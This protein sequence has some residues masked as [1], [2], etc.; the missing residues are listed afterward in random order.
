MPRLIIHHDDTFIAEVELD[1]PLFSIGRRANND[2]VLS[3]DGAVSGTHAQITVDGDTVIVEDQQSTNGTSVNDTPIRQKTLTEGDV[4]QI[5]RHRLRVAASLGSEA[6]LILGPDD[7]LA[8]LGWPEE[9][10]ANTP[11]G[12]GRLVACDAEADAPAIALQRALTTIG[13]PAAQLAAVAKRADGYY[14]LCISK[15]SGPE[16][17]INQQVLS[18]TLVRLKSGDVISIGPQRLRFEIDAA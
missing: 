12:A 7:G 11:L 16:P 3:G 18:R 15:G 1:R 5:G 17:K 2:I 8:E 13:E 6:T 14:A 9:S 4:I 10:A